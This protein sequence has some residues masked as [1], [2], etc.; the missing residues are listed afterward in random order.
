MPCFPQEPTA[1]RDAIYN[2]SRYREGLLLAGCRNMAGAAVG[3]LRKFF[4]SPRRNFKRSAV[5]ST[6]ASHLILAQT[7]SFRL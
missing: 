5:F 3:T 4:Q 6:S 1:L 2:Q 7:L